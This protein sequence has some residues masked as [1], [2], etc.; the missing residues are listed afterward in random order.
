MGLR[1]RLALV[2]T[3]GQ[4]DAA[5]LVIGFTDNA[6]PSSMAS[7]Y[8]RVRDRLLQRYGPP[9]VSR[10]SGLFKA[11]LNAEMAMGRFERSLEWRTQ[12][13]LLRFGVP[14]RLD[15]Q[16]RMEVVHATSLP[17]GSDWGLEALR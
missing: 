3:A 10:E 16:V 17:P 9:Q 4:L 12:G 6:N 1:Q 15:G 2:D 7:D 11:N 14:R 5:T 13:G 8:A